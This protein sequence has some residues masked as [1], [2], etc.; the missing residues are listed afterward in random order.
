MF[1]KSAKLLA[2]V[3]VSEEAPY[4]HLL[5]RLFYFRETWQELELSGLIHTLLDSPCKIL[6]RRITL[7]GIIMVTYPNG[8]HTLVLFADFSR[9]PGLVSGF[10]WSMTILCDALGGG[11]YHSDRV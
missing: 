11:L 9:T 6:H 5:Q 4:I 7:S 1:G 3:L 2:E 10:Q 8:G